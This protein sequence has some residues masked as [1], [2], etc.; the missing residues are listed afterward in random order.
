[1]IAMRI[2]Y[3]GKMI[4]IPSDAT[5][6]AADSDGE[7]FAYWQE[8]TR[9]EVFGWIPAQEHKCASVAKF[10]AV[11]NPFPG[12]ETS[13]QEVEAIKFQSAHLLLQPIGKTH[14]YMVVVSLTEDIAEPTK[15]TAHMIDSMEQAFKIAELY[16]VPLYEDGKQILEGDFN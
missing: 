15:Y 6:V 11:W 12:W 7:V 10:E 16:N 9:H 2:Q 4:D 14:H 8:P 3:L 13:L 1:M 5:H